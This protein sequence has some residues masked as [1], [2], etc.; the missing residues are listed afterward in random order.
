[1]QALRSL[2]RGRHG[3][4][5]TRGGR[6][7]SKGSTAVEDAPST[8]T[9]NTDSS[10][11]SSPSNSKG[12]NV[13]RLST[14]LNTQAESD[15]YTATALAKTRLLSEE[16]KAE[17]LKKAEE[18]LNKAIDDA[19]D[20]RLVPKRRVSHTLS[21]EN[22][23]PPVPGANPNAPPEWLE[24]IRKACFACI[25]GSETRTHHYAKTQGGRLMSV[26]EADKPP[27]RPP[28]PPAKPGEKKPSQ[29]DP[30]LIQ[31]MEAT[32]MAGV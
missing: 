19:V 29:T 24:R 26:M 13:R 28:R 25:L 6:R 23:R 11:T 30:S 17:E 20:P 32:S 4:E 1:M 9:E 22:V 8:N 5:W 12:H 3:R 27:V 2:T 7:A 15:E 14:F 21:P 31:A 18:Q 10:T 16:I